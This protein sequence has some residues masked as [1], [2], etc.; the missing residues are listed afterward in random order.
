MSRDPVSAAR[1]LLGTEPEH[2]DPL[3]VFADR[4]AYKVWIG[5]DAFV[6]KTDD[7]PRTTRNEIAGLQRANA[8]GVRVPD[9]VAVTDD[10]FA[11]RWVDGVSLRDHS[12]PDAWHDAGTQVR[13]VHDVGGGAPFGTGFGG[14]NPTRPDWRSFFELFADEMLTDCE[15]DL[16]LERE[17]GDR[18]RAALRAAPGLDAPNV[19][20]C[21]GDLQPEHV[22]VDPATDRVTAIIDWADHGSGDF[23]WDVAVL[24]IEDPE[25][26]HAFLDGY[27]ATREQRAAI[28]AVFSLYC[29]VRLAGE[30]GWLAEHGFPYADNLRRVREWRNA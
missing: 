6:V 1:E 28:D 25:P 9:V 13:L 11:M 15:R 30:A 27:G 21:H 16:G 23:V 12:T 29:A 18:I 22:L 17:D 4:V 7:D 26:R 2:L 14:F 19:V 3:V 20:W 10:A 8:A 24:T 5:D